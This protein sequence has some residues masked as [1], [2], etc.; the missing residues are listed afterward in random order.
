MYK[1]VINRR[2]SIPIDKIYAIEGHSS[3]HTW[4]RYI[5]ENGKKKISVS[6]DSLRD[7]SVKLHIQRAA[8]MITTK[9]DIKDKS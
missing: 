3:G 7:F 2:D 8:N 9:L 5:D 6:R 4:V 1:M